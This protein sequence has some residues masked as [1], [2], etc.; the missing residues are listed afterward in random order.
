MYTMIM[1]EQ[2]VGKGDMSRG[3]VSCRIYIPPFSRTCCPMPSIEDITNAPAVRDNTALDLS[4]IGQ[5]HVFL[6]DPTIQVNSSGSVLSPIQSRLLPMLEHRQ[7]QN[8]PSV[9][10]ARAGIF[11]ILGNKIANNLKIFV[12]IDEIRSR[13]VL[14]QL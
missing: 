4:Q 10:A 13:W 7:Q 6:I 1:D 8:A 12:E 3:N 2:C 5:V 11:H 14:C 9:A